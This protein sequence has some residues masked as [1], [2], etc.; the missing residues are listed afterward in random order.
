MAN[1]MQKDPMELAIATGHYPTFAAALGVAM[2]RCLAW[3]FQEETYDAFQLAKFAETFDDSSRDDASFYMVSI[4][5][6]IGVSPGVEYLTRWL[7][8]P[9]SSPKEKEA[10]VARMRQRVQEAYRCPHCGAVY[11][12]PEAKFCVECGTPRK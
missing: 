12:S 8:I 9:L 3:R 5:G 7:F 1:D 2:T 11:E 10:A 6:A 4:E